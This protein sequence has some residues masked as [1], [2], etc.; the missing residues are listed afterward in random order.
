[1][2]LMMM[3]VMVV[4]V[5]VAAVRGGGHRCSG[6]CHHGRMIRV[7]ALIEVVVNKRALTKEE[8]DTTLMM[9]TIKEEVY[10]G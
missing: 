10:K 5:V 6:H 4:V 9:K 2:L 1:M 3:G 7:V 8:M